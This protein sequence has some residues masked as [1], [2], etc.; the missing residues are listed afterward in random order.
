MFF[1]EEIKRIV[2]KNKIKKLGIFVDMDGVIADYRF[3]EGKNIID[4][5]SGVYINKRPIKTTI[6]N[7]KEIMKE[8]NGDLHIISSCL[9]EEQKEEKVEWI[10]KNMQFI[11]ENNINIIISKNFELRKE[12]KVDKILEIMKVKGYDYSILI[13]DTHEILFLALNKSQGKIIPMHVITL[14]D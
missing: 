2:L 3:G 8:I 6:N 10:N 7:L 13:D 12:L 1:V 9:F 11:N 14:L 5:V 4:N